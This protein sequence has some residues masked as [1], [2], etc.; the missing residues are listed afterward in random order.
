M[1]HIKE[2]IEDFP[3]LKKQIL[4]LLE[5]IPT[6]KNQISC[7]YL[8]NQNP[9][10]HCSV[11]SL[12]ELEEKDETKYNLIHPALTGSE[13]ETLIKKYNGYR[14]RIMVMPPRQTYSVHSD[15]SPRI[16][17]PILTNDQCWMI[18]PYH[19]KCARLVEGKAYWTDTTKFHTAINGHKNETR[20]HLVFCVSQ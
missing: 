19:S 16:H 6:V 18:W 20:V 10:W 13:I 5:K 3:I 14:A 8:E 17:I 15:F 1:I 9:D 4:D 2:E 7:Q 11:G 12:E